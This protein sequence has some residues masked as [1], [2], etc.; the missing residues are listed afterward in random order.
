M[1]TS[2]IILSFLLNID[3]QNIANVAGSVWMIHHIS[4]I[5]PAMITLVVNLS[6]SKLNEC[7]WIV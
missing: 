7:C 2:I 3:L 1:A 5:S 6:K 4:I